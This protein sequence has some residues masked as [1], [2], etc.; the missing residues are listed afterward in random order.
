MAQSGV[1]APNTTG[2]TVHGLS[3]SALTQCSHWHSERD[4]I[5]IRHKCCGDYYA[6]I[7]CHEALA[8]HPPQVW[9][10]AEQATTR[11]V[12]CGKC[13]HE[14]TIAEHSCQPEDH[15]VGQ[16]PNKEAAKTD[17]AEPA[18]NATHSFRQ[19]PWQKPKLQLRH[20]LLLDGSI[21]SQ[22]LGYDTVLDQPVQKHSAAVSGA[23]RWAADSPNGQLGYKFRNL[24]GP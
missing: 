22:D 5:A 4:I 20:S 11:A 7:S 17:H 19:Q 2:P 24:L 21:P 10:K 6:C 8:K 23:R 16:L 18:T 3:V 14:L 13:R 15:E 12:L 9:P 1:D